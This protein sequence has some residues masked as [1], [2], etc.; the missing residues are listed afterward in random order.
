M[1]KV[2]FICTCISTDVV[3]YLNMELYQRINVLLYCLIIYTLNVLAMYQLKY[4]YQCI[5]INS[6]LIG[7]EC[8]NKMYLES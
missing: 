3:M 4:M 2:I 5:R 6:T 1:L 8:K 7:K